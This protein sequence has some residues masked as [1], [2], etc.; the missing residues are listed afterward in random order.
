MYVYNI[1]PLYEWSPPKNMISYD[2]DGENVNV[3]E[4]LRVGEGVELISKFL[5]E[6]IVP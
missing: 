4:V 6:S 3:D 5:E 2:H 1:D